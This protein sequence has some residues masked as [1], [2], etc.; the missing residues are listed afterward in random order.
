MIKIERKKIK[1]KPFYYLSKRIKVDGNFKKIRVYVGKGVPNDLGLF[2]SKLE[3]KEIS[4]IDQDISRTHKTIEEYRIR[5]EYHFS[6]LSNK[7]MEIFWRDFAI[8]FIFESNSIEG[9]RL[10]ESE[11]ENIVKNKYIKKSLNR[12][13]VIEVENSIKAFDMIRNN[14]FS[15]NQNQIKLVHKII[16][17]GL[18]TK[19]GYKKENIIVN[20]KETCPVDKVRKE[21]TD[22][23]QWYERKNKKNNNQF[24]ITIKFHQKFELIHPFSDGNGRVGRL[25]LIWMLLQNKYGVI[26]FRNRNRMKYFS[27][28]NSADEGRVTNLYRHC[29]EVYKNTFKYLTN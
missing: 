2:Y 28:L 8:K 21:M 7:K 17:K 19:V 27:V 10:S 9:S 24:L 26:L 20:N 3:K 18:D 23:I 13:E 15:L 16:V 1:N 4:L 29:A 22:L 12:K 25:I 11:V 5:F 6:Q 14:E